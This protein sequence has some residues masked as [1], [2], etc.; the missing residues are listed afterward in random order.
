MENVTKFGERLLEL[1]VERNET[2]LDLAN[3]IGITR[4]SLSRYETNERIPNID[5][6]YS[7][8][9]HYNVSTDYL[10]G[11]SEIKSLDND[12]KIACKVTGLS[13]KTIQKLSDRE[14]LA[15]SSINRKNE[16]EST[17]YEEVLNKIL[18]SSEFYALVCNFAK[19]KDISS[20]LY[21]NKWFKIENIAKYDFS[22]EEMK[23]I[24]PTFINHSKN[25]KFIDY[26]RDCEI[27]RY[28]NLKIIEELSNTFDFMKH[29]S[30]FTKKQFLNYCDEST[31][32][33]ESNNAQHNPTQE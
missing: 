25:K 5:L 3:A 18:S 31:K 8:A 33:E 28:L 4:Q 32:K 23:N 14:I 12:I 21:F 17:F 30:T 16:N 11:M 26:D 2:Q 13:E 27:C 22:E 19:L 7:V 10:L 9:K 15:Y 20:I 6:I 1:R 24:T 29:L